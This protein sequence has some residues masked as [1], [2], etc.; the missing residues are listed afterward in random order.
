MTVDPIH[1]FEINKFFTIGKIWL[2]EIAFT[3]SAMFMLIAVLGITVVMIGFRPRVP[4]EPLQAAIG[5][6]IGVQHQNDAASV[7]QAN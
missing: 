5:A 2:R 3:N 4:A 7:M 1:Q 6:A